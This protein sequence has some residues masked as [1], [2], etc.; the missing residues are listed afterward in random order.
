[1]AEAVA[2]AAVFINVVPAAAEGRVVWCVAA[3]AV[4]GCA[5]ASAASAACISVVVVVV[6][7]GGGTSASAGASGLEA[8]GVVVS[9]RS[10]Q[11]YSGMLHWWQ[12]RSCHT[13]VAWL[14]AEI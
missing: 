5:Q 1:V 8:G 6:V 9:A 13:A 7:C 14:L 3:A 4:M 11:F 2:V 10:G 12:G